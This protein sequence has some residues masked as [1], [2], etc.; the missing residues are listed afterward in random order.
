MHPALTYPTTDAHRYG[1][2]RDARRRHTTEIRV[3]EELRRAR[4]HGVIHRPRS[5]LVAGHWAIRPLIAR[6]ASRAGCSGRAR[7]CPLCLHERTNLSGSTPNRC[8]RFCESQMEQT[9]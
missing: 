7:H 9:P 2:Y 4:R 8:Q 5:T 1:L 6:G 3:R